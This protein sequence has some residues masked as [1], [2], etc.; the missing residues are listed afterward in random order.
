MLDKTIGFAL[1]GS[2][3]TYA[4]A[5]AALLRLAFTSADGPEALNLAGD[6]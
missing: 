3:C 6:D 2:F 5:M 4:K 1:C